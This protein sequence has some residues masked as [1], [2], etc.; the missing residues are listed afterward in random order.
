MAT[1][2]MSGKEAARIRTNP[3]VREFAQS[4]QTG[5]WQTTEDAQLMALP[6]WGLE[7]LQQSV[8]GTASLAHSRAYA[9]DIKA[10]DPPKDARMVAWV[11]IAGLV[12]VVAKPIS[13]SAAKLAAGQLEHV[14]GP[15]VWSTSGREHGATVTRLTV[16]LPLYE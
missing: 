10:T 6:V 3:L 2:G 16:E 11:D 13:P 8:A 12:D 4:R 1:H 15:V 14:G 9:R 5:A 7:P